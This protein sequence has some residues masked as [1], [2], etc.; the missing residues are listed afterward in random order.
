MVVTVLVHQ[1][2]IHGQSWIIFKG[3]SLQT[4]NLRSRRILPG[5][6]VA[7]PRPLPTGYAPTE[8]Q[9]FL[10][11]IQEGYHTVPMGCGGA[12]LA[13]CSILGPP[14]LCY[15]TQLGPCSKAPKGMISAH[16]GTFLRSGRP[17]LLAHPTPCQFEHP[18][19]HRTGMVGR[20]R[21]V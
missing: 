7:G 18:R 8:R 16:K 4:C 14:G 10:V 19:R 15:S 5:A 21:Q 3:I 9:I 1:A 20:D 17:C 12:A 2:Q 6:V 13:L 11:Y